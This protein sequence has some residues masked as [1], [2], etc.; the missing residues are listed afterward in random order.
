MSHFV[1]E[2]GHAHFITF[3]TAGKKWLFKSPALY[4]LFVEHLDRAREKH[5]FYLFA[6]VVMPNHVHL[7]IFPKGTE[8]IPNILRTIKR[9]FA[10]HALQILRKSDPDLVKSQEVNHGNRTV[11][12][13]W[14][15]G[16]GL[17]RNITN[18][19][20]VRRAI[21]YM[22][23]N[24]VRRGLVEKPTDWTWSSARFWENGTTNPIR[25][26]VPEWLGRDPSKEQQ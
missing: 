15:P 1:H 7:L 21:E 6:Y 26:D 2:E 10:Y 24:P 4:Q 14:Q 19:E 9:P 25:M 5:Q 18:P 20:R 11:T 13:F 17:D 23:G 8:N 16:G 3:S 12:R 22:H